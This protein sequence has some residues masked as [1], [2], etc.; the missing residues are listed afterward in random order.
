MMVKAAEIAGL[1]RVACIAHCLH[2]SVNGALDKAQHLGAL[3]D[4]CHDLAKFFHCS[5]KMASTLEDQQHQVDSTVPSV[6]VVMDVVTRWNSTLLMVRR[7]LRLR[8]AIEMVFEDLLQSDKQARKK[9]KPLMLVE[10]DWDIVEEVVN[11]LRLMET[12]TLVFS[13][14]S[15]GL[16]AS[17]YP[18]V[19]S[20]RDELAGFKVQSDMVAKF[21]QELRRELKERFHLTDLIQTASVFHP[22]FNTLL[23]AF[24][25]NRFLLIRQRLQQEFD[26]LTKPGINPTQHSQQAQ[27][28]NNPGQDEDSA[29]HRFLKRQR[30]ALGEAASEDTRQNDEIERYFSRPMAANVVEP[31]EWWRLNNTKYPVMAILARK[32][33]AIPASSVASERMF[34]FAGGVCTDKRNRLSDDAVSD[35]VF[36]NYASKCLVDARLKRQ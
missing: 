18:W 32:Y 16:A 28:S 5:P 20:V 30:I 7:L 34:S 14:A 13:S 9:L 29:I 10:S 21:R 24:D 25:Q 26:N 1:N 11:V 35:I 3:V 6:V 31:L 22:T 33:L 4:K 12:M 17:L 2:N 36:C 23:S 19:A 8:I 27:T 15:K